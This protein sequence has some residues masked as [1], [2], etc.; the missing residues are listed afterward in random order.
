MADIAD[1][2]EQLQTRE[3]ADLLAGRVRYSGESAI[4]CAECGE[5][6]PEGRRQAVP[7]C[8]LCLECQ[9]LADRRATA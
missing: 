2:A 8:R 6:I 7:G 1:M 3:L 4:E 9:E 5:Q